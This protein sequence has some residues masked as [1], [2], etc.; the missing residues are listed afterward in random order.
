M[1]FP[2]PYSRTLL[3]ESRFDYIS[4]IEK[5]WIKF[6]YNY[7]QVISL[8]V[9][10]FPCTVTKEINQTV[11]TLTSVLPGCSEPHYVLPVCD[12]HLESSIWLQE[13]SWQNPLS[14]ALRKKANPQ[15]QQEGSLHLKPWITRLLSNSSQSW[16]ALFLKRKEREQEIGRGGEGR[17]EKEEERE[18]YI[19]LQ[20]YR[21]GV[22]HTLSVSFELWI[23]SFVAW[24]LSTG[25]AWLSLE[26]WTYQVKSSLFQ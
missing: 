17:G 8:D 25:R 4:K 6:Q 12:Y 7:L 16:Q 3:L 5:T 10:L 13:Y 2:V 24:I 23:K 20:N 19:E 22:V 11:F 21:T 18:R 9:S 15:L 1:W 26:L 14:S